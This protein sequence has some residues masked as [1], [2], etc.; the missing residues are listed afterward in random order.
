MG[1]QIT[2][3]RMMTLFAISV[4]NNC[5]IILILS[6]ILMI[7]TRVATPIIVNIEDIANS[8]RL[9]TGDSPPL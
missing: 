3:L 9:Q 1:R 2:G 7:S 4:C 5:N 8:C 6:T